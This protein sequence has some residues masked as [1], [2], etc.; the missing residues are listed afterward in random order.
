M[1]LSSIKRIL[2]GITGGIAAYKAAELVRLLVRQGIDV[3]V[4]IDALVDVGFLRWTAR[5]TI[6]RTDS[7]WGREPES[8]YVSVRRR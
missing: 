7:V 1:A 6:V 5:R 8:S 3:Q 4:V 2:V